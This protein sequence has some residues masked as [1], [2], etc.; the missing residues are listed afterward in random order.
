MV[1]GLMLLT[2]IRSRRSRGKLPN[3]AQ[4]HG[5]PGGDH[6]QISLKASDLYPGLRA[7][8]NRN[9]LGAAPSRA[10][11]TLAYGW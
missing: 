10:A 1:P 7:T 6:T 8:M 2:I 11:M 9:W 3:L 5:S 4:L